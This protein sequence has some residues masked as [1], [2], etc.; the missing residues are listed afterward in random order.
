VETGRVH[1]DRI[2]PMDAIQTFEGQEVIFV[3]DEDGIE[4]V[5]VQI[6]RRNDTAVE[7]LGDSIALGTPIVVKNSFL[8]KAELGKGSAEHGH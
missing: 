6:G 4:P 1:A 8:I 7:L 5:A 3:Q 2:V